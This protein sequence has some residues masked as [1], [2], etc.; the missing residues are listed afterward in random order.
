MPTLHRAVLLNWERWL[1][2]SKVAPTYTY[3]SRGPDLYLYRLCLFFFDSSPTLMSHR[4][5]ATSA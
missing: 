4:N 3:R 1:S 5:F 2:V